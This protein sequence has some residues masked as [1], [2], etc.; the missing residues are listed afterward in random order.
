MNE[1]EKIQLIQK[2]FWEYEITTEEAGILLKLS[3][4]PSKGITEKNYHTKLLSSLRWHKLI[5]IVPSGQFNVLLVEDN[6]KGLFPG[7]LAENY[8][9]VRRILSQ[10][11]I[12]ATE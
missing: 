1:Q 11:T 8:R 7:Q 4:L 5:Q 2:L 9:Y 3:A 10:A 12:S 6:L